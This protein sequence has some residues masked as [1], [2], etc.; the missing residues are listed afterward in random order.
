MGPSHRVRR[1]KRA[2]I[3]RLSTL[4]RRSGAGAAARST[5]DG[6]RPARV[7]QT[8]ALAA[9]PATISHRRKLRHETA[10]GY[11]LPPPRV[12]AP[13]PAPAPAAGTTAAAASAPSVAYREIDYLQVPTY[14]T[15]LGYVLIRT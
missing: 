6:T 5:V 13:A 1:S 7:H 2:V 12:P 4:G 14:F 8:P 10:S 9:A 15:E 11:Y 3:W